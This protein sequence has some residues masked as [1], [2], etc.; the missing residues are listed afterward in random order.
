MMD[1]TTLLEMT[2]EKF[3]KSSS[4]HHL[5]ISRGDMNLMIQERKINGVN[6]TLVSN[7]AIKVTTSPDLAD[8]ELQVAVGLSER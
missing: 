1:Y 7:P 2:I 3:F 8:G 4:S 6:Q 5:T